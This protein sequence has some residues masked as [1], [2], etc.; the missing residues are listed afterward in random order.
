MTTQRSLSRRAALVHLG[1]GG[2]GATLATQGLTASAQQG[3]PAATPTGMQSALD[4]WIAGWEAGD[5]AQMASAY[6]EAA[7][8]E[9]VPQQQLLSGRAAIEEYY[10]SYFAAFVIGSAN[11]D[12]AF[13]TED[14]A[15][16]EWTF[17]GEYTGEVAPLP[18]GTGQ[19]VTIRGANIMTLENGQ[20][21]AERVYPDIAGA[22]RQVEPIEVATPVE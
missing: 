14:N 18:P 12:T 22:L 4:T 13:A 17:F 1:V 15:G 10:A 2:I 21:V 9:V 19:L 8:V 16:V 11:V 7:V 3:T 6:A 5:P 20:I